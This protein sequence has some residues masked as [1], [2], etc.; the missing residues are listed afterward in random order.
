MMGNLGLALSIAGRLASARLN[1]EESVSFNESDDPALKNLARVFCILSNEK[2]WEV[3]QLL[4]L[5]FFEKPDT[6]VKTMPEPYLP[7]LRS[8]MFLR[9]VKAMVVVD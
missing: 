7:G 4:G 8:K 6:R 5:G 9:T 1:L 3:D 2:V